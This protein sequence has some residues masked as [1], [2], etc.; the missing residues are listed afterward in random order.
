VKSAL[1][2]RSKHS[3]KIDIADLCLVNV[4][5]ADRIVALDAAKYDDIDWALKGATDNPNVLF[6]ELRAMD[7][8]D[9]VESLTLL[10]TRYRN[11]LSAPVKL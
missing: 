3:S 6:A 9:I 5:E 8:S 11:M 7:N 2:A 1:P 4:N 10:A